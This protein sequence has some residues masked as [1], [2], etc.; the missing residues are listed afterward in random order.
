MHEEMYPFPGMAKNILTGDDEGIDSGDLVITDPA[1]SRDISQSLGISSPRGYR[2]HTVF[3]V[4]GG[5]EIEITNDAGK[6]ERYPA[7]LFHKSLP[8][9]DIKPTFTPNE[10]ILEK[11]VSPKEKGIGYGFK[12]ISVFGY[13][14]SYDPKLHSVGAAD[15][16]ERLKREPDNIYKV[17]NSVLFH[18]SPGEEIY[19]EGIGLTQGETY[20][21]LG[22]DTLMDGEMGIVVMNDY[23]KKSAYSTGF[24]KTAHDLL[25]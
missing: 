22:H 11:P 4:D 23:G 13:M 9:D 20:E 25:H 19:T 17:G 10:S 1:L 18:I 8:H 14:D 5:Q 7:S 24:F 2:V 6:L 16:I 3:F 15:T 12:G 21:I